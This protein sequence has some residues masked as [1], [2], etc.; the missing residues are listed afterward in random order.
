MWAQL[1]LAGLSALQNESNRMNDIASNVITQKYSPWT[2]QRADFS[3]QGK[4]NG[5]ATMLKGLGAG[6]AQDSMDE[7]AEAA[8]AEKALAEQKKE[9]DDDANYYSK[10]SADP[11]SVGARPISPGMAKTDTSAFG[12]SPAGIGNDNVAD[13]LNPW[14]S[15]ANHPSLMIFPERGA[16]NAQAMANPKFNPWA[17]LMGGY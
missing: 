6:M 13:K 7:A 2:G 14:D 10:L 9:W 16:P 5:M 17:S 11:A 4:Q 8:K 1:G 12:R 15:V 3:S